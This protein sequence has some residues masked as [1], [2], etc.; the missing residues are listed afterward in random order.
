MVAEGAIGQFF[1]RSDGAFE[2]HLAV[3]GHLQ[4]HR[5]APGQ[6]HAFTGIEPGEQPLAQLHGDRGGRSHDQQRMHADGD[7]DLQFF[8]HR[9]RLAQVAGTAA[10]AQP[11]HR[12]GVDALLLQPVHP[13]VWRAGFGVFGDHQP[14]G[15]DPAAISGPGAQQRQGIEVHRLPL[16]HLLAAGGGEI[17]IGPG[18]EHIQQHRAKAHRLPGPLGRTGLLQ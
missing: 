17:E 3:A 15:D 6:A 11:V 4:V 8:A 7:G 16:E 14:Q 10:H 18:P 9:R 12:H 5:F 1:A 13:H 2:H